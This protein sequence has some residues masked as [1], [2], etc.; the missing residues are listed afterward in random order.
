MLQSSIS[1]LYGEPIK[2]KFQVG[3]TCVWNQ[4]K[5]LLSDTA[6]RFLLLEQLIHLLQ[7]T[8]MRGYEISI[9]TK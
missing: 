1:E 3:I 8:K 2:N 7:N 6:L 5:I 4:N 9:Q